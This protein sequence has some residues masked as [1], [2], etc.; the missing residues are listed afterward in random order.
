MCASNE[1]SMLPHSCIPPPP[2]LSMCLPTWTSCH[3]GARRCQVRQLSDQRPLPL[4]CENATWHPCICWFCLISRVVGTACSMVPLSAKGVAI[5]FGTCGGV[6]APKQKPT[7]KYPYMQATSA[8]C[9]SMGTAPCSVFLAGVIP[10]PL[11]RMPGCDVGRTEG[12]GLLGSRLLCLQRIATPMLLS[13]RRAQYRI[14]DYY[15]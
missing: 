14:R 5:G 6:F 3:I 8:H 1:G 10:C 9:T 15:I 2:L 7:A 4:C 13:S 11:A 12:K